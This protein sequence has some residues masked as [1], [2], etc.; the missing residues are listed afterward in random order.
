VTHQLVVV[1]E[2]LTV[3]AGCQVKAEE[4]THP[5]QDSLQVDHIKWTALQGYLASEQPPIPLGPS[6]EPKHR[7]TVGS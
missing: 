6:S 3:S 2:A 1:Q 4:Q 7:P 5:G